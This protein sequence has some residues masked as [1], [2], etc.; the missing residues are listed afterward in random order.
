VAKFYKPDGSRHYEQSNYFPNE[1]LDIIQSKDQESGTGSELLCLV[2]PP[3][4][5]YPSP[6]P[7][8]PQTTVWNSCI[9]I[10][11][12]NVFVQYGTPPQDIW[13]QLN[14]SQNFF[15][16]K[17][18]SA[19]YTSTMGWGIITSANALYTNDSFDPWL[20]QQMLSANTYLHDNGYNQSIMDVAIEVPVRNVSFRVTSILANK[21]R[22]G[23][24]SPGD[25]IYGQAGIQVDNNPSQLSPEV[26]F[27]NEVKNGQV[28]GLGGTLFAGRDSSGPVATGPVGVM[29]IVPQ[30]AIATP[31]VQIVD[32]RSSVAFSYIVVNNGASGPFSST[33]LVN[34][35]GNAALSL[36]S[37]AVKALLTFLGIPEAGSIT[38]PLITG[39]GA[40]IFPSS[41]C[42]GLCAMDTFYMSGAG[43]MALD[44]GNQGGTIF[45][46][47]R[48]YNNTIYPD[49]L[50]GGQSPYDPSPQNVFG[51]AL[52][53]TPDYFVSSAIIEQD[54]EV[55]VSYGQP[56]ASGTAQVI[57]ASPAWPQG[58]QKPPYSLGIVVG[59]ISGFVSPSNYDSTPQALASC[60][61]TTPDTPINQAFIFWTANAN[62]PNHG[63]WLSS[64]VDGVSWTPGTL[65]T[66]PGLSGS[67]ISVGTTTLPLAACS[68]EGEI[69][70]MIYLFWIP[71]DG[72]NVIQFAV[73]AD[74]ISWWNGLA[75]LSNSS[76]Q[77]PAA[78]VFND[79]LFLYW[80]SND[81]SHVL[82]GSSY[83]GGTGGDGMP[84]AADGISPPWPAGQELFT[85][86][87][88]FSPLG[89]TTSSP[90]ACVFNGQI[91]LFWTN[92]VMPGV[93]PGLGANSILFSSSADGVTFSEA[94]RINGV[95]I[96]P[97]AISACV[98]ENQLFLF[99]K[100]E[101]PSNLIYYSS[102]WDG[103]TWGNGQVIN[104]I[105]CTP[106]APSALPF[107][108]LIS[109]FWQA[110]NGSQQIY[111]SASRPPVCIGSTGP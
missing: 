30:Y 86:L 28:L 39:L 55:A 65:A 82:Y 54:A 110:N 49:H 20:A 63:I 18:L 40:N 9:L 69:A 26:Y 106:T 108:R 80:T 98:F 84:R 100:S 41:G 48:E 19:F 46:L 27:G 2:F 81:N 64:S 56:T 15:A 72:S 3:P 43:V 59:G 70:L 67:S 89:T 95:D 78:C 51:V 33:P 91:Y 7:I 104:G 107:Q 12:N 90:A 57:V 4:N 68:Y 35:L 93:A 79:K 102:S 32:P 111:T 75:N 42:D 23:G 1:L 62:D 96:T 61:F 37:D 101:D 74:G 31:T 8:G 92:N 10:F 97:A 71:T 87:G 88:P 25:T 60:V 83:A 47:T 52:C 38:G 24:F 45:Q 5:P 22:S 73:S 103:Q 6:T 58:Q 29:Q 36:I 14:A 77:P 13:N 16:E 105:D 94:S 34:Q 76:P 50:L 85:V 99:W 17:V 53:Q 66:P 44:Y 11:D 21:I 109:L